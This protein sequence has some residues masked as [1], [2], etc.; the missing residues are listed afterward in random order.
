MHH[1]YMSYEDVPS[2]CSRDDRYFFLFFF[3]LITD[4]YWHA[5]HVTAAPRTTYYV[6][7][8]AVSW[9]FGYAGRCRL[10]GLRTWRII[11]DGRI[12]ARRATK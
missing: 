3:M 12:A 7:D 5:V 2:E 8:S 4:K 9:N 10:Y 1:T 11:A 6:R